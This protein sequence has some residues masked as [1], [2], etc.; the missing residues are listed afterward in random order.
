MGT[1][2]TKPTNWQEAR[3]LRAWQLKEA[4]WR[5]K[6]IAEALG[7]TPGAVSQWMKRAAE[8]GVEALRHE[9]PPGAVSKLSDR[10]LERLVGLLEKGAEHFGFGGNVWTQPRVAWLIKQEFGV[11]YHP[12]HVGRLLKKLKWSRQK[13]E[14]RASQR[15][16][17]AIEQWRTEGWSEIKK[18]PLPK[19]AP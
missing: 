4:G 17:K 10:Q 5:Q 13:P 18:R 11:S 12:S 14:R 8:G 3:R 1:K 7:V 16:E 9:P 15:D 6:D 2:E 19:G